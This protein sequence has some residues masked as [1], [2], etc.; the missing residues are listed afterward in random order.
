MRKLNMKEL[1]FASVIESMYKDLILDRIMQFDKAWYH[2]ADCQNE[3]DITRKWVSFEEQAIREQSR[4][5]PYFTYQFI[6]RHGKEEINTENYV[7]VEIREETVMHALCMFGTH[8]PLNM[9][10]DKFIYVLSLFTGVS[11]EWIDE[12]EQ[13]KAIKIEAI[14]AE[15]NIK[16]R[17]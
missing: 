6:N 15:Q 13:A 1:N 2:F 11:K 10:W 3:F 8:L 5:S 7:P 4:L 12:Y 17:E 16:I 9:K 14:L